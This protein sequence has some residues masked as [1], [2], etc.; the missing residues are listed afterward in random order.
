MIDN[1]PA[2]IASWAVVL[3]WIGAVVCLIDGILEARE[4]K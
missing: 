4:D 2:F 1:I 3:V